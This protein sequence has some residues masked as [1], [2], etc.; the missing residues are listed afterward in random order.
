MRSWNPRQAVLGLSVALAGGLF[1]TAALAQPPGRGP[2]EGTPKTV[3]R[4]V[5]EFTTG[6]QGEVNGMILSEGTEV[7][8]PLHFSDKVKAGLGLKDRVKVTGRLH[9]TKRGDTHLHASTIANLSNDKTI[10]VDEGRDPPPPPPPPS[11]CG[12]KGR[13][14]P[15]NKQPKTVT[16]SVPS[17]PRPLGAR[18]M[19]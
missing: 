12:K 8:W 19:A 4:T 13:R 16:A 5:R 11:G 15:R 18:S 9:V 3:R 10:A 17:S 7:H 1:A 6:R 14:R 2:E